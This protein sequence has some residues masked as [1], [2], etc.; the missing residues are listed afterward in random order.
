LLVVLTTNIANTSKKMNITFVVE[1]S[2]CHGCGTCESVCFEDA[3]SF[4][5]EAN[6]GIFL[7]VINEKCNYCGMCLKVCSGH[8]LNITHN[9]VHTYH[10]ELQ[11]D[12]LIGPFVSIYRAYSTDESIRSKGASGGVVTEIVKYLFEN[13]LVS[14]AILT[15]MKV[16]EPTLSEG[17]IAESIDELRKS[18]KSKYCPVPLNIM[19]KPY[20]RGDIVED[21][22]FVGL[23]HHVHGL[24]LVQEQ[25]D[26]VRSSLKYVIALFTAHV[27]SYRATEYILYKNNITPK[28]VEYLEYRG[29]GVPGRM[30][31][32]TK[33]GVSLEIPHLSWMYYGFC[34]PRYFYPVRDWLSFDK[35]SEWADFS[36]GD[37]WMDGLR[38][39]KGVSTV[40]TRTKSADSIIRGMVVCNRFKSVPMTSEQ[41]IKDQALE[42]KLNISA[43]IK[44]WKFFGGKVPD[45]QG[46][47]FNTSIWEC[48]KSLK[49]FLTVKLESYGINLKIIDFIIVSDYYLF[50]KP[51]E[52]LKKINRYLSV[53]KIKRSNLSKQ[54]S[55]FKVIMI[56]GYGWKDIGDEAMPHAVRA[57]LRRYLKENLDL[58]ML[59]PNPEATIAY[60]NE[61]SVSDFTHI[62]LRAYATNLQKLFT[63]IATILLLSGALLQKM[64]FRMNLWPS[65]R[66]ALDEIATSDAVFNVGGGNINSIIPYELYK[67]CTTYLVSSILGIPVYISGQTIGPFSN[68]FERYYARLCLNKTR[69]ISFRDKEISKERLEKIGVSLPRMYDAADDA[70]TL[71]GISSEQA[72]QI[73]EGE[74][75]RSI[76]MLKT[77]PLVFLNMKASLNLFKKRT[78]RKIDLGDEYRSMAMLADFLIEKY[79]CNI[80]FLPTDFSDEVD[81]RECHRNIKKRMRMTSKVF[82]FERESTD[83]E[84]IGLIKHADLVIGARYHFNVFA[85]SNSIP[86]IG[87]ASGVYQRTKLKGLASLCDLPQCY[88]DKELSDLEESDFIQFIEPVISSLPSINAKLLKIIP[89][90]KRNSLK[91]YDVLMEDFGIS[92]Q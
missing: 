28:D 15:R 1:S 91:V 59:S 16:D 64:G 60:H 75:G 29:G 50:K 63:F 46:K 36:C 87:I 68:S 6:L 10:P 39:Q 79:G 65:A 89:Q 17:Y 27:P 4:S 88:I 19:L 54:K 9:P 45:Y 23:P 57:N 13:A 26:N 49:F 66:K 90:L 5:L 83:K 70:I 43:R 55:N 12:S 69:L 30:L 31:I 77:C 44:L 80:I 34:F 2:L 67:K 76:E 58:V 92:K 53:L 11:H 38:D 35:L 18:Q 37:N 62:G 82:L 8:R 22:V 42:K 24:R 78:D 7:P 71:E 32:R 40:I 21:S 85:A 3:I 51:Y 73:L 61:K 84:L 74:I 48:I 86:F 41:L 14:K 56:G 25:F 52:K 72:K 33:N 20:V 81:D 47:Q